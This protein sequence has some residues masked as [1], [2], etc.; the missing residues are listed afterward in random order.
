MRTGALRSLTGALS[1]STLRLG[2]IASPGPLLSLGVL[3][4]EGRAFLERLG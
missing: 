2:S 4:G 3:F 1:G